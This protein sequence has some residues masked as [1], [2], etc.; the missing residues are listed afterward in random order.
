M[1]LLFICF[2]CFLSSQRL[3]AFSIMSN[4]NPPKILCVGISTMDTIA[5]L[6]NYPN[7]DEKVRSKTLQ[8][9]GGGNAAN[10]AVAMARLG[11]S[12]VHL[13]TAIGND[14]NGDSILKELKEEKVG[15]EYIERYEGNS[16][17][18]YIMVVGDTRTIIHQPATRDLSTDFVK[19]HLPLKDFHAVHFDCRH[20]EAAVY[21]SKQCVEFNIPYSVDAERPRDGLQE[22]MKNASIIICNSDYCSKALDQSLSNDEETNIERFKQVISIQAPN[23]LLAIMTRGSS[24]SYLLNLSND[25]DEHLEAEFSEP[26]IEKRYSTLWCDILRQDSQIT[27]TT[28]AGDAFQ[29]AFLSTVWNIKKS[30]LDWNNKTLSHALRIATRVASLKIAKTGA[31]S[32][33]PRQDDA[34]IM[35]EFKSIEKP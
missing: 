2:A 19:H 15:I 16:P 4:N 14:A 7:A 21:L 1:W 11:R 34:F 10:T 32:G 24:G 30:G 26:K 25:N 9:F 31:R 27:D 5:T 23:A 12:D 13:L 29:G 17:W 35:E 33:L 28:G 3:Q 22:L 18:S 20:P 6:D 8:H